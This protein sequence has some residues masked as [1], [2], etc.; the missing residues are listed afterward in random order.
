MRNFYY[1]LLL[2]LLPD[3]AVRAQVTIVPQVPPVGVMRKIQ[4]WNL[5]LV[6]AGNPLYV[7]VGMTLLNIRDGQ[8]VLQAITRPVLLNKGVTVIN[9]RTIGPVQYTYVSAMGSIDPD[10]NGFLAVGNYRACY[11]VNSGEN[12]S[13]TIAQDC[14][15]VEVQPLSP[16]QLNLPADTSVLPTAYPQFTWLP[17]MPLN[18]FSNPGYDLLV[19][20]VLPGQGPYEAVQKNIPVYTARNSKNLVNAYPASNKALDTGRVYAWEVIATNDDQFIAKSEVWTFRIAGVRPPPATEVHG[21]YILLRRDNDAAAGTYTLA[22]PSVIGVKLYSYNNDYT[23]S[24]R[25]LGEQGKVV[26]TTTQQVIHGDNFLTWPLGKFFEKGKLYI[27]ELSDGQGNNYTA[28]F[29]INK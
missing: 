19:V 7:T 9:A 24:L 27:I 16:P 28:R 3:T 25:I 26:W 15:P 23:A 21:N 6:N 17:P 11:K 4:L 20:E 5:S 22:D 1:F 2:L 18:L 8:P 14:L 12:N 29:T 10:P 13:Y